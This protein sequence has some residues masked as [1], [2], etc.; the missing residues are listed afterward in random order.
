MLIDQISIFVSNQQGRLTD[1]TSVLSDA[2]IDI[3]AFS[4]ADTTEFGILRLIV[5]DPDGAM[6]ALKGNNLIVRKTKVIAARFGDTPGSLNKVLQYLTDANIP[7]EYAYAFVTPEN[8]EACVILRAGDND[9]AIKTLD[10]NGVKLLT[11]GDICK[12]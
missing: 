6:E 5:D 2:G 4:L 7:I 11:S 8:N 10:E 3:R 12:L 1:I 9:L